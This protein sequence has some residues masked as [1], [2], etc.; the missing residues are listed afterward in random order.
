MN[1]M[2]KKMI[3]ILVLGANGQVGT[4]VCFYLKYFKGVEVTAVVRNEYSSAILSR[5]NIKCLFG[6]LYTD[7]EILSAIVEADVVLD[8]AAYATGSVKEVNEFYRA[9]LTYVIAHMQNDSNYVFASSMNALGF[10]DRSPKLRYHLFPSSI[11]CASK[12]YAEKLSISLGKKYN[13]NVFIF[14]FGQVHGVTQKSTIVL[15][16]LINDGYSFEIPDTPSWTIFTYSIAEA[17][18]SVS[19]KLEVPGVYTL[20]SPHE[21]SWEELLNYIA[22]KDNKTVTTTIVSNKGGSLKHYI[23]GIKRMIYRLLSDRRDFWRAN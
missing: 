23:S 5:L 14:R 1:Y 22:A 6:D 20:V 11:Y 7:N 21:W 3:S 19:N 12:R 2:N 9:R 16:K 15:R 17:L 4:E 10:S 13:V 18:I 8:L